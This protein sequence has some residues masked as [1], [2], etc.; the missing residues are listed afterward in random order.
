MPVLATIL[1][2]SYTKLVQVIFIVLSFT[3]LDYPDGSKVVWL[4]DGNITFGRGNHLPLFIVSL[5]LLIIV[6]IPYTALLILFPL[7]TNIVY[8]ESK[9]VRYLRKPN[10]LKDYI[11]AY[12]NPYKDHPHC[13]IYWPSL[14]LVTRAFHIIVFAS[15][16]GDPGVNLFVTTATAFLLVILNLAV[17]GVYKIHLLTVLEISYLL[18]IG[19]LS[20]ATAASNLLGVN[21]ATVVY[22]SIIIAVIT[23]ASAYIKFYQELIARVIKHRYMTWCSKILDRE[24]SNISDL[25]HDSHDLPNSGQPKLCVTTTTIEGVPEEE[26]NDTAEQQAEVS[27]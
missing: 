8:F 24:S 12:L 16:R 6:V 9:L 14:L 3:G 21:H 22:L 13:G 25:D 27:L 4:Y 1:L 10:L 23:F 5:I 18:N 26:E 2:L 15:T 7:I 19:V 11:D 20:A 17:G